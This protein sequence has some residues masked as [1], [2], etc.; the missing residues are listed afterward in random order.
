MRRRELLKAT[1]L[2]AVAD[3]EAVT[4]SAEDGEPATPGEGERQ[5]ILARLPDPTETPDGRYD[6]TVA[7]RLDEDVLQ[8][9]ELLAD[10]D[11][12]ASL[13]SS[14]VTLTMG[15]GVPS[16]A[17]EP[18]DALRRR[19][20]DRT[21]TVEGRPLFVRRGRYKQRVVLVDEGT[22]VL[23]RAAE[24]APIRSLV[25]S[26]A[27]PRTEPL[28]ERLPAVAAVRERLGSGT[29]LSLSPSGGRS[30]GD[31]PEPVA[32]GSRLA[33][34]APGG[35]LRT[36]AV[37][38]SAAAGRTALD[39]AGGSI[40]EEAAVTQEGAAVVTDRSVPERELSLVE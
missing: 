37:Y 3:L 32:T 1:G 10:A 33:L 6:V 26:V 28:A 24:L 14:R 30:S 17:S 34:R 9:P 36:V 7:R 31:A 27:A 15:L 21:G 20:F 8:A 11:A 16:G 13:V 12:H 25:Q 39:R 38:E 35:R 29:V 4:A 23:G 5:D 22:V 18:V 2:A 40:P 19:G